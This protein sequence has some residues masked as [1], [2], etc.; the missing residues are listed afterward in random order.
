MDIPLFSYQ[1]A[2]HPAR[3]GAQD[4]FLAGEISLWQWYFRHEKPPPQRGF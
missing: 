2:Q 3:G 1:E 4:F